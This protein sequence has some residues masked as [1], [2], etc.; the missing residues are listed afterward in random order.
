MRRMGL[1][2][3][4][5]LEDEVIVATD[6]SELLTNAGYELTVAH[7]YEKA[8]SIAVEFQ[9][10]L[11]LCDIDL[12]TSKNGVDF[13]KELTKLFPSVEIIYVTAF[14]SPEAVDAASETSPLN[15]I[16]KPWNE[17]Q[18]LT[19]VAIAFNYISNKQ[20]QSDLLSLLSLSEYRVLELIARQQSSKEIATLLNI[21]EKTVRNHR[22]NIIKKLSLPNDNNSLLKWALLNFKTF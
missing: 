5:I 16:V 1:K 17:K 6:L 18:M 14:S 19:T 12:G 8:L 4:M 13:S 3:I 20:Q 2:K 7:S 11:I 15:Y 21:A 10:H 22:Y 9:P